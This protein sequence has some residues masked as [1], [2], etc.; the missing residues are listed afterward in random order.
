MLLI[1]NIINMIYSNYITFDNMQLYLEYLMRYT[2]FRWAEI[3]PLY[4]VLASSP[5][6]IRKI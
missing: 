3:K 6:P 4:C 2:K 1:L 5:Q